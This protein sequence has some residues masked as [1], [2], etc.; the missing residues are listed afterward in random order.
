MQKHLK[1]AFSSIIRF[2]KISPS[3]QKSSKINIK[4]TNYINNKTEQCVTM[5]DDI[6]FATL[7]NNRLDRKIKV[8]KQLGY[9]NW[10]KGAQNNI[11]KNEWTSNRKIIRNLNLN[12]NLKIESDA[13]NSFDMNNLKHYFGGETGNIFNCYYTAKN[14][15]F[16]NELKK[17]Y[18]PLDIKIET[19]ISN[20]K[21]L[22]LNNYMLDLLKN[23]RK[24]I[25]NR[26]YGYKDA[27]DNE[28]NLL[29]KDIKSFENY[30]EKEKLKLKKLEAELFKTINESG[31]FLETIKQKT[32]EHR[33]LL[34]DIKKTI[35]NIIKFK[36]YT[37]FA[38]IL[39]GI[40]NKNLTK[41]DFGEDKMA[42]ST[43]TENILDQVIKRI[44]TQSEE[45]F[46]QNFGEITEEL[47]VDPL[48]IYTIIKTKEKMV[49][50]LLA[51]K[52]NINLDRVM[53]LRDYK[54][55]IEM[56]ENKYNTFLKEYMIYLEE[57]ETEMK[58]VKLVEPNQKKQ[59]F[60]IYL[61][62]LFYEIKKCLMKE[63]K[64][65]KY[66]PDKLIYRD[67]VIPTLKELKNKELFINK[68]FDQMEF[69]ENTDKTLFTKFVNEN[70]NY[71]KN[72]KLREEKESLFLKDFERRNKIAKK[73]NQ[74]IITGKYKYKLP[75]N[76][77]RFKS[78][79]KDHKNKIKN[80]LI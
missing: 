63:E 52:E 38:F 70:K 16:K 50:K 36:N 39:L 5:T 61:V 8:I 69:Y 11:Y 9:K 6:G 30:K 3:Q 17:K 78:M 55:Q 47:T 79:S 65:Q 31:A 62:N 43:V 75:I 32:H 19:I 10:K 58:K 15:K 40:E 1:K 13:F 18:S 42:L 44:F 21:N 33:A 35:K 7:I 80:N 60:Y 24:N 71:N 26:E 20:T 68:L 37:V 76:L 41:C 22:C 72:I 54:Q 66:D 4:T 57:Y 59:D 28:Y 53:S 67:L 49:L 27:L 12:N 45:L 51:Q 77:N 46:D 29:N 64:L 56:Y 25:Y 23:E 74:I 2:P 48:K 14:Y 73:I 34:D